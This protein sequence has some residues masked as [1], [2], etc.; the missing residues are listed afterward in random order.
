MAPTYAGLIDFPEV[1]LETGE[2]VDDEVADH[3]ERDEGRQRFCHPAR[4]GRE[5]VAED[6]CHLGG[7]EK[8]IPAVQVSE[9]PDVDADAR[10]TESDENAEPSNDVTEG[11]PKDQLNEVERG[12]AEKEPGPRERGQHQ[13]VVPQ[14][15]GAFAQVDEVDEEV[16]RVWKERSHGTNGT[17]TLT[18]RRRCARTNATM[19]RHSGTQAS[20]RLQT[21]KR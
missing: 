5:L 2:A 21:R 4:D 16:G 18:S 12:E 3:E 7:V 13:R 19:A 6:V 1:E 11:T 10:E 20:T 8:C 9:P 14:W 17:T 15:C